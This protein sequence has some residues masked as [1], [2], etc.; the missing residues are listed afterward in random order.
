M[1]ASAKTA[2][3]V[4]LSVVLGVF[5]FPILGYGVYL[6]VCWLRIHTS[7]IY[8]A[9]YPYAAVGL[10]CFVVG[11][12]TL[13]AGLYGVWRRSFLGLLLIIPLIVEFAAAEILPDQHPGVFSLVADTNYLSE[14]RS[15]L[16]AWYDRNHRFPTSE[17]EIKKCSR[18]SPNESV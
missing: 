4:L 3:K 15:S 11:S 17:A 2:F 1:G 14:V 9:D 13:L 5:S 6:F 16:T 12:L 10:A 18:T 7:S 8:Y